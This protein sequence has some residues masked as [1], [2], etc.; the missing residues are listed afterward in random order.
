MKAEDKHPEEIP[1]EGNSR[2][3]EL[4]ELQREIAQRIKDNQRFLEGFL[5]DDYDDDAD[6]DDDEDHDFEEL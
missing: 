6:E 3:S 4:D 5:A 1:P 2:F